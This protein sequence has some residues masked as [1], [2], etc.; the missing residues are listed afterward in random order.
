MSL[1][2][3]ASPADAC[4]SRHGRRIRADYVLRF[5]APVM[6]I[7]DLVWFA[8]VHLAV[9]VERFAAEMNARL[10]EDRQFVVAL[11]ESHF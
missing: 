7:G 5:V 4:S 11:F 2:E 3:T 9:N 8:A 10:G 1:A 6:A